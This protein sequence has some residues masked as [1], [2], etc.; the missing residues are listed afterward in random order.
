MLNPLCAPP[1]GGGGAPADGE[2]DAVSPG[3]ER[4]PAADGAGG[5]AGRGAAGQQRPGDAQQVT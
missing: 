5:A 1:Q 3:G 2:P 4:P